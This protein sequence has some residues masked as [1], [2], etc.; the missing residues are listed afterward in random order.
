M[1]VA[2]AERGPFVFVHIPKTAGTSFRAA[3]VERLGE[4]AVAMDYGRTSERTS[5]VVRELLYERG[6]LPA[7]VDALRGTRMVVGHF[8]ATKYLPLLPDA[9]LVT[10]LREPLRRLES[11]FVAAAATQGFGGTFDEF[12]ERPDAR[13]KQSDHLRPLSPRHFDFVGRTESYEDDLFR[14]GRWYG[15]RFPLRRINV[16]NA[17]SP[18]RYDTGTLE[19][20]AALHAEDLALDALAIRVR[21]LGLPPAPAERPRTHGQW[22]RTPNGGIRGHAFALTSLEPIEVVAEVAGEVVATF[23]ADEPR[24]QLVKQQHR[25]D[26]RAGFFLPS[27][28]RAEL[29]A[30]GPLRF[31]ARASGERL[32]EVLPMDLGA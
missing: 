31:R 5:P 16:R 3:V 30:A 23:V 12:L 29:E 1:T 7:L 4:S 14:F 8:P 10:F 13:N 28:R 25:L 24:P 27:A 9:P 21:A 11:E 20:L 6:D 15:E 26:P 18:A 19:R 2:P 22:A 32:A 17:P